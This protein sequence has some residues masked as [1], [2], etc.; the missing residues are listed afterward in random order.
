M[1]VL[2][3]QH[4]NLLKVCVFMIF[5]FSIFRIIYLVRFIDE[6]LYQHHL[7]EIFSALITGVRFDTQVICYSLLLPYIFNFL[8][9]IP[10]QI[11]RNIVVY[12]S[13]TYTILIFSFL[14]LILLIDQQFYTYFQSHINILVYGFL[15]DDTNA[16]LASVW[17]DHPVVILFICFLI[18]LFCIIKVIV[19][20]FN[21]NITVNKDISNRSTFL[22]L[23]LIFIF[24]GFGGRGSFG[25]FPLQID[26]STVSDN[27]FINSI[28]LNGVY[29]FEK[30]I[31]E[32]HNSRKTPTRQ[33]VLEDS[34]YDSLTEIFSDYYSVAQDSFFSNNKLDYFFKTTPYDSLLESCRPN[35]IFIMMESFGGYYL[36]FHSEKLNLLGQLED[37][38][39]E[40]VLFLNFL[41]STQGT[42]YSLENIM[43]NKDYPIISN[44][45]KRFETFKSS[46]ALPYYNSGYETIFITGGKLGWRN[47][48]EFVPNQFFKE[49][50]GK[51]KIIRKNPISTTNTWGVYDEFLFEDIFSQLNDSA[52]Q[53]IFAL[54]TTNHT[55]YELPYNYVDYPINITDS[56][57]QLIM[58][59]QDVA[60]ANFRAYQY[61]NDCLGRFLK[62][63]KESEYS[64]NTIVAVTGDHN[65][66]A[67]FPIHNSSIEEKEKYIV[68]FFLSIPEKYKNSLYINEERIGSHKDI[69]PT[70]INL[71][72]S[73]AKYF[74]LGNNLFDKRVADSFF[75]AINDSCSFSD[76]AMSEDILKKKVRARRILNK[77]YFAE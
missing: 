40:G 54:S 49:V 16:V 60:K 10:K 17:S 36:K 41:S 65:S 32:R 50:Y 48:N 28:T 3:K 14:V 34:G 15:E 74:N 59:N 62:R 5:L 8:H 57:S 37:H 6:D 19:Y 26:D 70:L 1:R 2:L 4:I 46:A 13:K 35:V 66:Y 51:S 55:P 71:S 39:E 38:I 7:I 9:L 44:T 67:L 29:T 23:I 30:A 11:V 58:A 77:Y 64:E 45:N 27:R 53:F 25:V 73:N 31:E 18:I 12:F 61:A 33:K 20:I 56:L 24:F 72:L 22:L 52:S 21:S 68:P 63:L 69:F 75:Y 76:H 42:I 47:L 43:I